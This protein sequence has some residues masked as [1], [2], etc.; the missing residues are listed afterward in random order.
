MYGKVRDSADRE[1]DPAFR[2]L[3]GLFSDSRNLIFIDY[4]H[5][6]ESANARVAAEMTVGVI[7]AIRGLQLDT[8][9]PGD[10]RG[11]SSFGGVK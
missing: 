2:D 1:P 7:D 8:R 9:K 10:D 6:T 4:C 3:S 11:G 5:T